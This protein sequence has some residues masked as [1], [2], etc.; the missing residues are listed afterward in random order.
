MARDV[1]PLRKKSAKSW[2][3]ADTNDAMAQKC[4]L[5]HRGK[6][7]LFG[8]FPLGIGYDNT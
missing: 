7:S 8:E 4:A 6:A 1:T 3:K 5:K 2:R